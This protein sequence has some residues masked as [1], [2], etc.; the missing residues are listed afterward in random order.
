[1]NIFQKY[2]QNQ[3]HWERLFDHLNRPSPKNA[4]NEIWILRGNTGFMIESFE[5]KEN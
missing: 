4:I 1:M 3:N 2:P 5:P